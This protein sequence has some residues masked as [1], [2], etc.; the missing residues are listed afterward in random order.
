VNSVDSHDSSSLL[1][2]MKALVWHFVTNSRKV[3]TSS[4]LCQPQRDFSAIS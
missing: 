1:C 2:V 4:L 3:M